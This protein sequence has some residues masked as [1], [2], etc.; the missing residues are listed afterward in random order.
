M[1]FHNWEQGIQY[2]AEKWNSPT[3]H[4]THKLSENS[5][6]FLLTFLKYIKVF[7]IYSTLIYIIKEGSKY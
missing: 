2:T 7:Y 5:D 6:L 3:I 4:I 1:H